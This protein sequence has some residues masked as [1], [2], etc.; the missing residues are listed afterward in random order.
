VKKHKPASHTSL[1]DV[2]LAAMVHIVAL[3]NDL[4]AAQAE[5]VRLQGVIRE[6]TASVQTEVINR[7]KE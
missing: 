4:L 2:A 3:E 7:E 1:P 5:I 6:L